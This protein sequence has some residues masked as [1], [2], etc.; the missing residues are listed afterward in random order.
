MTNPAAADWERHTAAA[1]D[2]SAATSVANPSEQSLQA[3]TVAVPSSQCRFRR[4]ACWTFAAVVLI[5]G[6]VGW[7]WGPGWIGRWLVV[8]R[9]L[10]RPVD[11]C[12]VLGGR[13]ETRALLAAEIFRQGYCR[14]IWFPDPPAPPV[15]VCDYPS[16]RTLLTAIVGQ[17]GVPASA[18]RIIPGHPTSTATEAE[19]MVNAIV[20]GEVPRPRRLAVVTDDYHTRRAALIFRRALKQ[21]PHTQNDPSIELLLVS[22]P[23]DHFGPT[24]WWKSETGLQTYCLECLKLVREFF[25]W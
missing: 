2:G 9:P 1:T 12:Y 22:A 7:A 23:T 4:T 5:A 25:V 19:L 16:E 21:M 11:A 20:G 17:E 8:G 24:D 3:G 6:A 13:A 18:V 15:T 10:S 14:E